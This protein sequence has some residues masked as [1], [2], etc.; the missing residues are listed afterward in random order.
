MAS[1]VKAGQPLR[2]F[3][4]SPA[5]IGVPEALR[6]ELAA[7]LAE[8]GLPFALLRKLQRTLRE[9]GAPVAGESLPPPQGASAPAVPSRAG[10]A[11]ETASLLLPRAK[12]GGRV[13]I[14][15]L[16]PRGRKR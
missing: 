4:S 16:P 6:A 5:A 14:A 3:L 1:S 11:P 15:R 12:A 7:A 13:R 8:G 10:W 9:E 2:R